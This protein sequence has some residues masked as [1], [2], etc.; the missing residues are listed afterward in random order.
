[1][2][3]GFDDGGR[4]DKSQRNDAQET[5]GCLEVLGCHGFRG[6][7]NCKIWATYVNPQEIRMEGGLFTLGGVVVGALLAFFLTRTQKRE[8]W[9]R[10]RRVEECKQL[11]SQMTVT[12]FEIH[13]WKFNIHGDTNASTRAYNDS[14]KEFQRIL[15]SSLFIANEIENAHIG[16][17]WLEA[18]NTLIARSNVIAFDAA[19]HALRNE[20][21]DIGLKSV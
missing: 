14:A 15:G 5:H 21:V 8:E 19:Y 12:A 13:D 11:L 20:I 4:H 1:M 6:C 10:D 2:D 3:K 18:T 9:L 16:A 17:R 7:F